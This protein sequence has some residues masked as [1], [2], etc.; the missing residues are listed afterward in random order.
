MLS[1]AIVGVHGVG[2]TA[3]AAMLEGLGYRYVKVEAI[4]FAQPLPPIHRQLF[5]YTK[6]VADFIREMYQPTKKPKV[7]D[8]H[9]L[10][11]IP[12]TQYWLMKN[13]HSEK[14]VAKLTNALET[15]LLNMPRVSLLVALRPRNISTVLT[16]IKM[17]QRFNSREELDIRYVT[18]VNDGILSLVEKVGKKIAFRT[19]VVEAEKEMEIRARIINEYL[20]KV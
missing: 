17:R 11:V 7:F 18:F 8:S 15:I 12:Y 5:F 10:V 3:T 4:D 20:S 9:P 19:Y 14:D 13:G 16:R 6:Y 2:K 1:V